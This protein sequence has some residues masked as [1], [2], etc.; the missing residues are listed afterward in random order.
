MTEPKS[1]R[2]QI[3][4]HLSPPPRIVSKAKTKSAR[5][6]QRIVEASRVRAKPTHTESVVK[7]GSTVLYHGR[8]VTFQEF[9]ESTGMAVVKLPRQK[10]PIFVRATDLQKSQ[11]NESFLGMTPIGFTYVEPRRPEMVQLEDLRPEDIGLDLTGLLEDD[12]EDHDKPGGKSGAHDDG[13][14]AD[15]GANI[16]HTDRSDVDNLPKPSDTIATAYSDEIPPKEEGSPLSI[17]TGAEPAKL[18]QAPD[19]DGYDYP[20][21]APNIPTPHFGGDEMGNSR[22]PTMGSG[23][24]AGD[25]QDDRTDEDADP[26]AEGESA[27]D[28]WKAHQFKPKGQKTESY[29][30]QSRVVSEVLDTV[31]LP[32]GKT[33]FPGPNGT[34]SLPPGEGGFNNLR[35]SVPPTP[36]SIMPGGNT[37]ARPG[38]NPVGQATPTQMY[39]SGSA[40][41]QPG[42]GVTPLGAPGS[43]GNF[44]NA[45]M[46]SGPPGTSPTGPATPTQMYGSGSSPMS[47]P[48]K[49]E[50]YRNRKFNFLLKE[51]DDL[52]G[53]ADK[54]PKEGD[55]ISVSLAA[56]ASIL[57]TAQKCGGDEMTLRAMIE[58]LAEV[59]KGKTLGAEDLRAVASH[60]NG[61]E[62]E[63]I[64]NR[65]AGRPD[66]DGMDS[67]A[68]D[69][70]GGEHHFGGSDDSGPPEFGSDEPEDDASDDDDHETPSGDGEETSSGK[71]KLFGG[72]GEAKSFYGITTDDIIREEKMSDDDELRLLKKRSGMRYWS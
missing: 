13:K 60:M 25:G 22:P 39:G 49:A 33:G 21:D 14:E 29:K 12:D 56:M 65:D 59:G 1:L 66:H 36:T 48:M 20:A 71:K 5:P 50:S 2:A 3:L 68:D 40:N 62:C 8:P 44:H 32:N 47:G 26:E 38:T 6:P 46:N 27:E 67:D 37:A 9:N 35:S 41:M 23:H 57:C 69:E 15:D 52:L 64:S 61:E 30:R 7:K 16:R 72:M 43:P 24:D 4:E 54:E 28:K 55:S 11:L 17:E 63:E 70:A 18:W 45:V 31:Q 19:W 34:A 42:G 51:I 58:A 10:E 53:H